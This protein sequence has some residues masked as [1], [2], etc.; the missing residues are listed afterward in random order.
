MASKIAVA[1]A[2]VLS[3]SPLWGQDLQDNIVSQL[4]SQGYSRIEI[5]RTFLGRTRIVATHKNLWREIV[6]NPSTGLILRDY[7]VDKNGPSHK[8]RKGLFNTK[9]G[10]GG[11]G[12][13]DNEGEDSDGDG[14]DG[15]GEDGGDG[16]EGNDGGDDGGDEGGD[17]GGDGE[18]GGNDGGEG[19]DGGGEDGGDGGEG[20]GDGGDD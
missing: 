18:D 2:L 15:D 3:G 10:P 19:D 20:D 16:G 4:K 7:S 1:M 11:I 14:E 13:G 6:I 17:D 8:T 12:G 5:H 9:S